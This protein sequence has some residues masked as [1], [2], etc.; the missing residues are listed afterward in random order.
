LG[1]GYRSAQ[2]RVAALMA[3]LEAHTRFQAGVQAA[4]RGFPEADR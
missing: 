1:V 2:R 3:A 4:L